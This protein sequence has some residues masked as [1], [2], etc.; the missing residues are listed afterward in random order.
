MANG[1]EDLIK[2]ENDFKIMKENSLN[3]INKLWKYEYNLSIVDDLIIVQSM[4]KGR[5]RT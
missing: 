1:V 5:F 4:C 2:M 3:H